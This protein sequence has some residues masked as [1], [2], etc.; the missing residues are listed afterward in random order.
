[1]LVTPSS[2]HLLSSTQEKTQ[3]ER[4]EPVLALVAATCRFKAPLDS[5]CITSS[6]AQQGA[7]AIRCRAQYHWIAWHTSCGP[8]VTPAVNMHDMKGNGQQWLS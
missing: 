4:L 5:S 8:Q 7:P 2:V 6:A 1:M 3:W